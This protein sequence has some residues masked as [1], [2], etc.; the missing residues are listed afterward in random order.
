M[1]NLRTI[2]SLLLITIMIIPSV[3]YATPRDLGSEYF[4]NILDTLGIDTESEDA[5]VF[6]NAY[7][8]SEYFRN[9]IVPMMLEEAAN[10]VEEVVQPTYEELVKNQIGNYQFT[11]NGT[12]FTMQTLP[13]AYYGNIDF[14]SYSAYMGKGA[15]TNTTSKAY[16]FLNSPYTYIGDYGLYRR[17]VDTTSQ[18]YVNGQ[19]DYVVALGT[20]YNKN[21]NTGERFLVVTTTGWFTI[22]TGD[23][24]ANRDTDKYNMF[25]LGPKGKASMIEYIVNTRSLH[26]SI[27][28]SGNV[29]E[30]PDPNIKG[31]ILYMYKMSK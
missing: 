27:R 28:T 5:T 31:K 19:D 1:K 23:A 15:V 24:Q 6:I 16:K 29:V 7:N 25:I 22:T 2:I 9:H 20:F 21:Q 17:C 14:S 10:Q 12:T 13:S 11:I 3:V 8:Q 26:P 18:F 30:G 4:V